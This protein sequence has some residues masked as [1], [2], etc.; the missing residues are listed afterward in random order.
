MGKLRGSPVPDDILQY[1]N[2]LQ[3][4][5][6]DSEDDDGQQTDDGSPAATA[7]NANKIKNP[8]MK[9][10]RSADIESAVSSLSI[11]GRKTSV[12]DDAMPTPDPK[13]TEEQLRAAFQEIDTDGSQELDKA[14][15]RQ[16]A[17]LVG[18]VWSDKQLQHVFNLMD[19]DGNS[20]GFVDFEE[21]ATFWLGEDWWVKKPEAG[22][23]S[24]NSNTV[25]AGFGEKC[26]R[27]SRFLREKEAALHTAKKKEKQVEP[28]SVFVMSADSATS[29]NRER[30]ELMDKIQEIHEN[31][32][33]RLED[34]LNTHAES[35]VEAEVWETCARES[36]SEEKTIQQLGWHEDHTKAAKRALNATIEKET[37]VNAAA[38]K[39][40]GRARVVQV[41]WRCFLKE[42]LAHMPTGGQ[43][44][45]RQ[46][47]WDSQQENGSVG[48]PEQIKD[49][50][51]AFVKASQGEL[52][53]VLDAE[54]L[55]LDTAVE[56]VIQSLT[57][58]VQS[59]DLKIESLISR[60]SK[61][62]D[63][64]P[65]KIKVSG[66]QGD[67]AAANGTYCADGLRACWG[68][69]VYLQQ[70]DKATDREP[71]F[72]FYDQAYVKDDA[73]GISQ[74]AD[75]KWV[76]GPSQNSDRC[77]AY[78]QEAVYDGVVENLPHPCCN[79]RSHW[80][81]YDVV[82]NKWLEGPGDHCPG[83]SVVGVSGDTYQDYISKSIVEQSEMRKMISRQVDDDGF[84]ARV[85]SKLARHSLRKSEGGGIQRKN[86][87][88][89]VRK[90][91]AKE[92]RKIQTAI[93][94][95][96]LAAHDDKKLA[97]PPDNDFVENHELVRTIVTKFVS[98]VEHKHKQRAIHKRQFLLR[99]SRPSMSKAFFSWKMISRS[100]KANKDVVSNMFAEPETPWNV[101]HPRSKFTNSWEGVQAFLL[102]YVAFTIPYR[103]CFN[104]E[105]EGAAFVFDVLVDLYF[106]CDVIFNYHTAFYDGTGDLAGVKDGP[107]GQPVADLRAMYWNYMKGWASIDLLSVMPTIAMLFIDS[108]SKSSDSGGDDMEVNSSQAKVLK[109]IRL[110]RL[111]KLLR[112][113][114]AARLFKK[115]EEHFGPALS[116]VLMF[117][118]L[119]LILH[120]ITC[121]WFVIGT[122]PGY[123]LD[124][125][126]SRSVGWL[127][128]VYSFDHCNCYDNATTFAQFYPNKLFDPRFAQASPPADS[129]FRTNGTYF[130]PYDQ[131]CHSLD[132]Q[133]PNM[134][135]CDPSAP[136]PEISDY[137]IKSLFTVMRDPQI[138]DK[139]KLSLREMMFAIAVAMVM[140]SCWGI[141]AGTFSTIFASNQLASQTYKMRIK[142]LKEF[143]RIKELPHGM[144]EKLEAHYY[145]L[146]PDKMMIDEED[147]IGDL[148][149]QLREE[150][151][152]TLYGRQLYSVPLF[153]NLNVQV[154]TELCTKLVPL[155]ALKGA[156]IAREGTKG[157]HMFCI[158]SGQIKITEKISDG[159]DA[160]RLRHWIED[161]YSHANRDIK[162]FKPSVHQ[163]VEVLATRVRRIA[164][165]KGSSED[166]SGAISPSKPSKLSAAMSLPNSRNVVDE[167]DSDDDDD[168]EL[169]QRLREAAKSAK[170][171]RVWLKDLLYDDEL[172]DTCREN[173]TN[174]RQL[175]VEAARLE[176]INY[177]G[178]LELTKADP[179]GPDITVVGESSSELAGTGAE[180]ICGALMSGEVLLDLI[181]LLVPRLAQSDKTKKSSV[182]RNLQN[183]IDIAT[184]VEG[185]SSQRIRA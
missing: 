47:T 52:E 81:V 156:T 140:G 30:A 168:D 4:A 172:I 79:V 76:I 61:L 116:L 162:L 40:F 100:N 10:F 60:K 48:S 115:Y 143:C 96:I 133:L 161:V 183:F 57:E 153:L 94:F 70:F 85:R 177:D 33:H 174:L 126:Q 167:S 15:V 99:M 11:V 180:Q 36:F 101:R 129:R 105:V 29:I 65:R 83:L 66:L 141:V 145:H 73:T 131:K 125:A 78:M 46:T 138:H 124:T 158:S 8:M 80:M 49:A 111:A 151:V 93:I 128:F 173:Q 137:Y 152:G 160:G 62:A 37:N 164:R 23:D 17:A 185:M 169:Q 2:P 114:R 148:P 142:Q 58:E 97:L 175:I 110:I 139:Y 104:L 34:A 43:A 122:M 119:G 32:F 3:A 92:L 132:K 68:R 5:R 50:A 166:S 77:T 134:P 55:P 54:T 27:L 130:D 127:Q 38:D 135:I 63:A 51:R 74:W 59:R 109:A 121:I 69:P 67:A 64:T 90:F 123:S 41:N 91:H 72:L 35:R 120:T 13:V 144:R 31:E 113:V 95:N 184:D 157:T 154:L 12:D 107:E 147:V 6:S 179:K 117:G 87:M 118:V 39:G 26:G 86:Y 181:K 159:D 84:A 103:L 18:A 163:L 98:S 108:S 20:N 165:E 21:F 1:G 182:E 149:P 42:E 112:L 82:K 45:H 71:Y 9:K 178:L 14:E 75:G 24:R 150:L 89:Q 136:I 56:A 88:M 19:D 106:I 171:G 44:L 102:V 22:D 170:V 25:C 53:A 7:H 176:R 146:Y 16:A 155:P 28:E